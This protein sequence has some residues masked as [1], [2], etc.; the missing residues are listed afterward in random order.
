MS[1]SIPTHK[2][3]EHPAAQVPAPDR[4]LHPT[5]GPLVAREVDEN[6]C[7]DF[8]TKTEC[9]GYLSAEVVCPHLH[10][11]PS[12]HPDR[13]LDGKSIIWIRDPAYAT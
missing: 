2:N 9:V 3:T 4:F 8:S 12:C 10:D 13:R 6:Y 1:M 5:L 11:G 7:V